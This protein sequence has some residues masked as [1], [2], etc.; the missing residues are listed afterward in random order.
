MVGANHLRPVRAEPCITWHEFLQKFRIDIRCIIT[1]IVLQWLN[2]GFKNHP[3]SLHGVYLNILSGC[4]CV[5]RC[6]L[7]LCVGRSE[8][9]GFCLSFK[10][11]WLLLFSDIGPSAASYHHSRA[12]SC[13][14]ICRDITTKWALYTSYYSLIVQGFPTFFN[15]K[16]KI[17][18]GPVY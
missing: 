13:A 9:F 11:W 12:E 18:E 14:C 2:Y 6:T 10:L 4:M 3:F 8:D 17:G 5:D 16:R 15:S 1:I 7:T